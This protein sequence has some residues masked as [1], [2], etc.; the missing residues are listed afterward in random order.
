[1]RSGRDKDMTILSWF[2]SPEYQNR[3]VQE[4]GSENALPPIYRIQTESK[5]A[6]LAKDIFS[7]LIFPIGIYRLLHSL[8]GRIIVPATYSASLHSAKLSAYRVSE[9]PARWTSGENSKA[10]SQW[11]YRR[12]TID[13]DGNQIDTLIMG[14]DE[15]LH[16]KRWVLFANG[17]AEHYETATYER[18][19]TLRSLNSN[20]IFFNY[21]Q[22]GAST[23]SVD[24][25]TMAKAYRAV[26]QFLEDQENGIG[27]TEIIGWGSFIGGGVQADALDGYAFKPHVQYRFVFDRTFSSLKSAATRCTNQIVGLLVQALGWNMSPMR[28]CERTDLKKFVYEDLKAPSWQTSTL[29]IAA[30]EKHLPGVCLFDELLMQKVND[31]F[32]PESEVDPSISVEIAERHYEESRLR[33]LSLLETA[34]SLSH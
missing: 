29:A 18:Q 1:M 30:I 2:G 16:G 4:L 21:P 9:D 33:L 24:R 11:K 8:V 32:L 34:P 3:I 12:L 28:T 17:D 25:N 27:A 26:L 14:R 15:T 19:K 31:S 7:V 10:D 23:G 5:I 22:V 13:V 20:G 6:K